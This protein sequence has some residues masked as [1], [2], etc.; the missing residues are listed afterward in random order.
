MPTTE[1]ATHVLEHAKIKA[2]G[3]ERMAAE[4]NERAQHGIAEACA[5]LLN[6]C[7]IKGLSRANDSCYQSV[8]KSKV[9]TATSRLH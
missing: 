3:Q 8:R 6:H 2:A 5:Q 4:N 9:A 7:H 1:Q